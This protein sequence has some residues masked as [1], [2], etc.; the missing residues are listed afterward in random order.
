MPDRQNFTP[1]QRRSALLCNAGYLKDHRVDGVEMALAFEA[2]RRAG[3]VYYCENCLFCHTDAG[4]FDLDHLVPDQKLRLW[5]ASAQSRIAMNMV[6]LCKSRQKGDLGCNQSKSSGFYVPRNCGLAFTRREI[7]M[8]AF[9]V[10]ARLFEW[11][12]TH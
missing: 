4:Y 11:A 1:A 3:Q 8:N 12:Q 9:P 10:H 5:D 7:D 6:V 2:L